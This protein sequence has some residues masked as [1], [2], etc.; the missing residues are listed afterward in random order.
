MFRLNLPAK[1]MQ[2]KIKLQPIETRNSRK[3]RQVIQNK[4]CYNIQKDLH[5]ALYT[6]AIC[7]VTTEYATTCYT[8]YKLLY[9]SKRT[10]KLAASFITSCFKKITVSVTGC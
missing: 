4:K 6:H 10:Q 7:I 1:Q 5:L 8:L 9:Y 2:S 3:F